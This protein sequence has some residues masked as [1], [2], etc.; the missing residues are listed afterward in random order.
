[1]SETGSKGNIHELGRIRFGCRNISTGER[2]P[3]VAVADQRFR[4]DMNT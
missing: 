2:L 4:N 1:M 3:E